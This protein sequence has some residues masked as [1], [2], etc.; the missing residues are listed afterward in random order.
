MLRQ[1]RF[2]DLCCW[3]SEEMEGRCQMQRMGLPQAPGKDEVWWGEVSQHWEKGT[4]TRDHSESGNMEGNGE[5]G[6][7][8]RET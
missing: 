5:I 3:L 6:R 7:E 1:V 4:E 8:A 2:P